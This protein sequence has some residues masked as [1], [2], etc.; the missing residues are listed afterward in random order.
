MV[1]VT[2]LADS[3]WAEAR[4]LVLA[5]HP[6][7]ETL[8]AGALIASASAPDQL[9]AVVFLTDGAGSHPHADEASRRRLVQTRRAEARLALEHLCGGKAPE[10]VFLDWPDAHPHP[11]GS[12]AAV[13][14]A[15]RLADLC[16]ERGVT[17]LAVTALHEPHCDHAAAARLAR[18]VVGWTGPRLDLFEYQVW[19]DQPPAGARR[20]IRTESVPT[21]V[22]MEALQ[23][24]QSQ[25]TDL[26][27]PGF[28]LDPAQH[29]MP[30]RDILYLWERS[31]AA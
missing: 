27:G 29:D 28:R 2:D 21:A 14:T 5:P 18:A 25:L 30:E 8:G 22:R 11:E 15:A 4:W 10:I 17:A 19:A 20:A 3:V 13:A 26:L 24:H 1:E 6:D 9:A 23:A 31:D 16:L 7:D 12:A